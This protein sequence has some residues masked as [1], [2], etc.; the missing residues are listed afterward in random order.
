MVQLLIFLSSHK[1]LL[2]ICTGSQR[3]KLEV[4][5][6]LA[7]IIGP[8]SKKSPVRTEPESSKHFHT[9]NYYL[10]DVST[11][12]YFYK[13]TLFLREVLCS[14]QNWADITEFSYTP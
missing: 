5:H 14:Q 10:Y 2:L 6:D 11:E 7:I 4:N 9:L 8:K 3:T 1:T 13:Y 12:Y